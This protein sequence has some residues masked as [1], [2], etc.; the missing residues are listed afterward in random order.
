[1]DFQ[2]DGFEGSVNEE[3]IFK[4]VFFGNGSS[5]S[6]M[7][8]PRKTFSYEHGP[9]KIN[10]A[11]LCSSSELSTVSSYSYSRNI[12]LDECYNPTENIKTSSAPDSL[13]CKWT[14]VEGDNVNASAKRIKLSTD[15]A[16]DSVPNLVKVKESSDSVRDPVSTNCCP[17]E[18]CD[19]ESFTFHIVESSRQGI[20]SSCYLLKHFVERDSNLGDPDAKRTSLNLEG[21]DEP[22][23]VNKVSASPV[24]QES[25]M[26]RL[27]VASPDTL[28][29][30]FGS[31]LHLEVGQMKFPCPELDASLKTDLSRDPRPLLHYHVVHLF[32]AAGWSIERVKRPC[33]RYME[34]VYRSPQGRAFREFS[35]AWRA[36]GELLF[37]DRCSF[38]KEVD[39]KEWTGIHQF[40][41]DLSD[42]L[43]KVGKEM[44]QLGATTSL[45]QCWVILD[46]YVVVVFI[47]RKIGTLRR[48]DSVRA[49]CSIGVNGNNKTEAFVTLTNEDNSICNLS[50]DKNAS[51]L[52][53]NS[54]SAK[55]AL[56]EAAL[57]DLDGGNCAFD[58]QTCDTSF[59][60]YYGH[61]EDGTMKFLTRVSNYDPNFGNGLNCMGSHCNEP[62]NKIDTE[63]LTSLPAYFSGSSCKPRCLADGP[64]PSGN[65]DNV[66]RISGLTSP[67]EDSTLYCSDEQTSENHVEKPNEMVKNVQTCSLVEEE[68]VEVPL[69]DK[70]DNNLEESPNDC[71]NYTS[72]DLSHSCASGVVQKSSQNEEGGLH[73]SASML[74]TENKVPPIHSILKKKGRRKC[75]KISEIKPSLPPQID[76]VSVTPVKKTELWDIDGNCSQLDMI[77]DQKS[78]IAD[79]KIVDSHE[80]SLSLSPISC[81]SER[82]G[83]KFKKNF[84]SLKGSKTRKKK[85][86]ECQIEDDDLLVS[87][88]IRNKDVSSSAAG[89][90]HIRKYLKSRAKMNRKRQK[91]SCKL[92]LRSLGNG[93][94]N[95]KDGKWYAVGARTVLS[96][97][98][99]AGVIS[100]NDIIQYQSPKDGSVVKYG[101]ITGDGIICNCCN[102]LLS[103]SEFKSH[104]G[105]KFNRPCLNL[106]LNS[107]RPFMLCQLQA[108]STEYKTRRSRT[109]T[110]QVDEDDRNDDS[111]GICGDGG[112]LICCDNCPS[113]F[114]HSCLSIQELPEGNWYCLN[115]TCRICGGL[116]NYEETSS[117]SN[118]LKCS[119]CEQKYHGQC[120]KQK[121][122][123]SGVESHIWFCS[124]SCQKIYTA[125]QT[126]LG[127]INQIANGL[128]WMLLRCIHNDQKILSTP[129]L[130]MMAECNS[131]LVVALTIME[132]CFLSMVD[133]RTGIDMIPHLVYSWKSS[134]PRLDFHGFYTVILEKDDVLLCVASIRVH[135]SELAEMPLI[136]T[137]SKYRRQGM[138]RRLLNAIEEMLLSFKVKKLVIAAIPSLV[139]T[140]T[141]GFG[142]VPV[143]NDE[144]QSLHRFN[145][146]VFPGTV[147]LKKALYVSGGQNTETRE[148]VQLDTDTK[149]QCD[150]N[151]ACPRMEM[152]CLNYLELQEH[153]G[154]K[155]MDDHKG[156]SAPIDSSTLQ[157]VESNGMNTSSAQKPVES[158]LQ[159]DGNC[160]TD[161]VGG[162]TETRTHEAKEPLKVEVGIECD[163]QVSEGKSW[164]EGVHAAAMTRFV[165]PVVLT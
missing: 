138:C 13:P 14:S 81:H 112:E 53:D 133:P 90:S 48:G 85:L 20:I 19:S 75:K 10:D 61:T 69:D 160:C 59:S 150:S 89:F 27:L 57:K 154:E 28:N 25:S 99:D 118:A 147:L 98:L 17:V 15:E 52:H 34:T 165:E 117:S 146:M 123:D 40:L 161:I 67:D 157:L 125:L 129:R 2:D 44:N 92:L 77:E 65:S 116:V 134:F 35:K 9:C 137:C 30:K 24:S 119:Q 145:L 46:P 127:L 136:A 122:I 84:D 80:K 32:I 93:E 33:R 70:G 151:D 51:P 4:E 110:V 47:G 124:W 6:N 97:L 12:K 49:T 149:R 3:I 111:C 101:R 94:K 156:I 142:F 159:S 63:D 162:K 155:M 45:A 38:V 144:K 104:A 31:P 36:C 8:C 60:H 96:W 43:L 18:D 128:S 109:R 71:P 158:V 126:R 91:S 153:N 86:N 39:S 107:G 143:E 29:E 1:M 108:W 106:F 7:R 139:E 95:Y 115:C 16:S 140:W 55:S 152:K 131:R 5:R 26:T 132:E 78:H 120:L 163:I 83:S 135:G 64:V 50:A 114:H 56:T 100:S 62:G 68:K 58:E 73:F 113:T 76:I 121:D 141:E 102:V 82:K 79:T 11:S 148:G 74:K 103:I 42:T 130:A 105:F 41:F 23:M 66:V 164:D 72:D 21:N 37:A 88:I 87:A 54:P 22:N